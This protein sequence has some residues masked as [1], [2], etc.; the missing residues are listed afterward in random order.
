MKKLKLIK[1]YRNGKTYSRKTAELVLK[2]VLKKIK[3]V[4]EKDEFIYRITK[5]VLFGSYIN[6]N[7]EKIGDLDIALYV[8]LKDRSKDEIE[9][10]LLRAKTSLVEVPFLL[11]FIY[12]REEIFKYI[13]DRKKILQLHYGNKVDEDSKKCNEL[14][15]YIYL[16]KYK[17]IYERR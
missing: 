9:Q 4:N 5:A 7:K 15:S 2:N 17:I 11:R 1:P 13:K 10:N 8:D 6:S 16:D 14:V 3:E 12:G